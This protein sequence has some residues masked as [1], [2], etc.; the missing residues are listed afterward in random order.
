MLQ[1]MKVEMQLAT[2]VDICQAI[3][4]ERIECNKRISKI[5]NESKSNKEEIVELIKRLKEEKCTLQEMS[6][7]R[8][9]R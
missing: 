9:K 6:N 4:A 3:T 8:V 1:D 7:E 5:Q 2:V